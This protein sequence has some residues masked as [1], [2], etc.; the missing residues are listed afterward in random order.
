MKRL[1]SLLILA[2]LVS[3]APSGSAVRARVWLVKASPVLVNG[4]G[5]APR[6]RVMVTVTAGKAKLRRAVL[7]TGR[8]RIAAGWK[9]SFA[10]GCRSITVVARGS[11]GR[12]ALWREVAN[13]CPPIGKL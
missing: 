4:T 6:E 8:G 13:D 2:A 9:G 7:A 3:A 10:G 5:F 11:S 12:S 1:A